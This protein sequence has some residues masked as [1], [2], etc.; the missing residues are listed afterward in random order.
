VLWLGLSKDLGNLVCIVRHASDDK[1]AVA[2][3]GT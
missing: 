3:R 2:V 1:I